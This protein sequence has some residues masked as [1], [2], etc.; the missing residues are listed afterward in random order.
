MISKN[1][2]SYL[3]LGGLVLFG[4]FYFIIDLFGSS[5]LSEHCAMLPGADGCEKYEG[6]Y[7]ETSKLLTRDTTDLS[8]VKKSTVYEASQGKL[9]QLKIDPVKKMIG[10]K[11]IRMYGYNSQI[12]GPLIKVSQGETIYVNVSNNLDMETT[13]H[14]HGI[15]LKNQFDGVPHTTQEAIRPGSSF[16]YELTFPDAGIYWYHPHVRED[17]QQELGLYGNILVIPE[18]EDYYNKVN[19]EEF[20]FLDDIQMTGNDI[21]PVYKEKINQVLMGRFGNTMLINGEERYD[22]N[23]KKGDV[24]RFYL[25]NAANTRLFNFSIKD[26]KL[27]VI[28]SDGGNYEKEFL[29]DS[30]IISPSERSVVEAL[31]DKPGNYNILHTNPD[32]TYILGSV[33]VLNEKTNIDYSSQFNKIKNNEQVSENIEKYKS[34]INNEPDVN[35]KLDV[36]LPG[37]RMM[38]QHMQMNHADESGLEWEDVMQMMNL[39]S[40]D[41]VID[42]KITDIQTGKSNMDIKYTWKVGD[43]VKIRIKND[44]NSPHP[45]QHPIHLHGQR[46]LVLANDGVPNDNMVWKDTVLVPTGKEIEILVDMTN[47]GKW[48]THCHIAEHLSDGMM[49]EFEVKE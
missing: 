4:F 29:A 1:N 43:K 3:I 8:L 48:M 39:G 10:G 46:F 36:D 38:G 20:I 25:T 28:G 30:V 16:M 14:W 18:K 21:T 44:E 23:V 31:F 37:M 15:R 24:V 45:M 9:M 42:W 13:V 47:P 26:S 49:F 11:E 22:I 7:T 27:K 40:S 32:K 6:E 35:L 33:N 5:I 17:Y 12:P 34:W 41:R 2:L 19:K